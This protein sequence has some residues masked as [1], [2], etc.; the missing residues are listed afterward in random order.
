MT[1]VCAKDDPSLISSLQAKYGAKSV[2]MLSSGNWTEYDIASEV[3]AIIVE[4]SECQKSIRAEYP[5]I[6]A[7]AIAPN[8]EEAIKLLKIGIKGY[9]NQKMREENLFLALETI[10]NGHIWLPPDILVRMIDLIPQRQPAPTEETLLS[11]LSKREK[12]VAEYV[13]RGMT[14][15]EIAEKMFVSLRTIKAHLSSIYDKTG[16]RNRL[17]LG[18]RLK[19][20]LSAAK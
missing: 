19:G 14:N 12:E 8:I 4:S 16:F 9:G 7:L 11:R 18:L 5:P 1:I 6:L 20:Y 2:V 3:E 13:F 17:E 15:Q 10:K